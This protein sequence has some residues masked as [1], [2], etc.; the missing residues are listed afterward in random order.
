M[1]T[2]IHKIKLDY[3][4]SD[5][6]NQEKCIYLQSKQPNFVKPHQENHQ[7][8]YYSSIETQN[9]NTNDSDSVIMD[10]DERYDHKNLHKHNHRE[11]GY[12]E[13]IIKPSKKILHYPISDNNKYQTEESDLS[14]HE[15]LSTHLSNQQN[16]SKQYIEIPTKMYR[17]SMPFEY[18]TIPR[19]QDKFNNENVRYVFRNDNRVHTRS[20]R[21]REKNVREKSECLFNCKH[22]GIGQFAI[23]K[24]EQLNQKKSNN[25]TKL[26]FDQHKS[27]ENK[28][29]VI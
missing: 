4:N 20:R 14:N 27:N 9:P 11:P 5:L 17:E 12:R 24:N 15:R 26:N 19:N 6:N 13:Y 3:E 29:K 21:R 16:Y 23:L 2:P 10:I 1:T 25:D 28:L 7:N 18:W 22:N 8:E